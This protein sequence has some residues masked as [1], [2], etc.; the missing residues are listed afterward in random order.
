MLSSVAAINDLFLH[1]PVPMLAVREQAGHLS[2]A[3]CNTAF[4]NLCERK[5]ETLTDAPASLLL[6]VEGHA[7]PGPAIARSLA[8]GG[9]LGLDAAVLALGH[10]RRIRIL[11]QGLGIGSGLPKVE[12]IFL[13]IARDLSEEIRQSS[14]KDNVERMLSA[15][16]AN[17]HLPLLMVGPDARII[18]AN[19]AAARLFDYATEGMMGRHLSMLFPAADWRAMGDRLLKDLTGEFEYRGPV[20]MTSGKGAPLKLEVR[21][22]PMGE[23]GGKAMRMLTFCPFEPPLPDSRA[24]LEG[25]RNSLTVGNSLVAGR[26]QILG[27]DDIS[28]AFGD[29]WGAMREQALSIAERTIRQELSPQDHLQRMPDDSFVIGFKDMSEADAAAKARRIADSIRDRLLGNASLKGRVET[30]VTTVAS[31][32][33]AERPEEDLANLLVRKLASR[34]DEGRRHVQALLR[35]AMTKASLDPHIV[36]RPDGV[37]L[38]YWMAELAYPWRQQITAALTAVG[39]DDVAGFEADLVTLSV[40]I[41]WYAVRRRDGTL[42]VPLRF[43]NLMQPRQLDRYVAVI[44]N[45]PQ[46]LRQCIML[47]LTH[48]PPGTASSRIVGMVQTLGPYCVGVVLELPGMDY[49]LDPMGTRVGIVSLDYRRLDYTDPNVRVRVRRLVRNY[50]LR[51]L[52]VLVQNVPDRDEAVKLVFDGVDMVTIVR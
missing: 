44:R 22:M 24:G 36:V 41:D 14:A 42:V 23:I 45:L 25:I 27:L 38:P 30:T 5:L 43:E 49:V 17:I 19:P 6:P 26:L 16:I 9:A 37:P 12:H 28:T 33:L 7:D 48:L 50:H 35:D 1:F 47:H 8:Q 52:K 11:G 13:A 15:V 21:G 3:F 29:R 51:K 4:A 10:R 18:L 2:L 31:T 32:D 46:A 39:D 20:G 40:A 34:R